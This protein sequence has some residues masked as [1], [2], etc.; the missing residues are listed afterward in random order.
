MIDILEV[1]TAGV[2]WEP[3]FR[4]DCF[5]MP[6]SGCEE[7]QRWGRRRI[8]ARE[9]DMALRV[10]QLRQFFRQHRRNP[11]YNEMMT[12]FGYR[13]K[14]AVFGLLRR[15][16]ESGHII[17]EGRKFSLTSKITGG[18]RWLGTVQAGFPSPAEEEL[19]ETLSL[20]EFLIKNPEAMFLLTVS[21]DSM[22]DAGIYPGDIVLVE[23]GATPK[24]NDIVIAQVDDEWTLKYFIRDK[25]GVRL[26]PANRKY[27]AIIPSRSLVIGGVVRTVIRK[28]D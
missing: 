12:L 1:L 5:Y 15:L 28:Y 10:R 19:A 17:K 16:D 7:G 8:M 9:I 26:E 20:D 3:K 23:R 22:V 4:Y 25:N 13:S 14:N 21:G 2:D 27:A 18:L 24:N 6:L 11:G